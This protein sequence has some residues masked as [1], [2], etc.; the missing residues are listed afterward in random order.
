MI[1]IYRYIGVPTYLAKLQ[2]C[3]DCNVNLYGFIRKS[4]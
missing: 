3:N 2:V 4:D 1:L